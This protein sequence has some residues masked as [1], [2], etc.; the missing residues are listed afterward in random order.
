MSGFRIDVGNP[1]GEF[2]DL[3]QFFGLKQMFPALLKF[4]AGDIDAF[5]Q[6]LYFCPERLD[7]VGFIERAAFVSAGGEGQEPNRHED[8]VQEQYGKR[9]PQTDG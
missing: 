1:G 3:R 7:L 8:P 6:P 2:S 5:D 9:N 4:D